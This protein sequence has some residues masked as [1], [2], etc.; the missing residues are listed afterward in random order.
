MPARVAP[1]AVD[2]Y[3]PF[4]ASYISRVHESDPV[5]LLA[6]QPDMLRAACVG[7]TDAAAH[8]RYAPGKWSVKQ[9]LG[10]LS[11]AER[12]LSYRLFR[13]G[14]GDAT[15]LSGFDENVYVDASGSDERALSALMEDFERARASTL[16]IVEGM[17]PDAWDRRGVANGAPVSARALLFIIGGH[18]EHHCAILRERYGVTVPPAN[19]P[20]A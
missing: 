15:P 7:L 20:S 16:R 11:D 19:V 5:A 9:V 4:Y 3:A 8:F 12:I 13:I 1:P 10:H 2:E 17:T 18:V 14:R 6:R